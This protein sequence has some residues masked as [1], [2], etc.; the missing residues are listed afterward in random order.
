MLL[1]TQRLT[2][3]FFRFKAPK[4]K[5]YL[6][7]SMNFNNRD[8]TLNTILIFDEWLEEDA[9]AV[10]DNTTRRS[11]IASFYVIAIDGSNH[12]ISGIDHECK[13]ITIAKTQ[14]TSVDVLIEIYGKFTI[15]SKTDLILEWFRKGR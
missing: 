7:E 13:Y 8:S 11:Q 14:A 15:A 3:D 6:I 10:D 1:I 5:M 12:S 2:D 4:G 9:G